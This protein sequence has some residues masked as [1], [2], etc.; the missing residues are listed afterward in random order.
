MSSTVCFKKC[1]YYCCFL[2]SAN[3]FFH[4]GS[5][6]RDAAARNFSARFRNY[7]GLSQSRAATI[8]LYCLL[9]LHLVRCMRGCK[10]IHFSTSSSDCNSSIRLMIISSKAERSRGYRANGRRHPSQPTQTGVVVPSKL[11]QQHC[12]LAALVLFQVF[13]FIILNCFLS[14]IHFFLHPKGRFPE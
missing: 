3:Y 10:F 5:E 12:C 4:P 7:T 1:I 14:S 2:L 8:Q 13:I 11:N 6:H 9:L